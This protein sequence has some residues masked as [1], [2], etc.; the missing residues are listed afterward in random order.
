MRR[1]HLPILEPCAEDWSAM[2]GD[3]RRRHCSSC[4][5]E[6]LHLSAMTAEEARETLA[7]HA[8]EQVC[9]RYSCDAQDNVVFAPRRPAP[10]RAAALATALAACTGSEGPIA[11]EPPVVVV[12]LDEACDEEP[13]VEGPELCEGEVAEVIEGDLV[14]GT[15]EGG[16]IGYVEGVT[17]G[18]MVAPVIMAPALPLPVSEPARPGQAEKPWHPR[19]V[20]PLDTWMGAVSPDL[21]AGVV[22]RRRDEGDD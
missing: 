9:V 12:E 20:L 17:M 5:R 22:P 14:E 6:V 3:A 7:A 15:V 19:H 1:S 21:L 4:A 13:V 18:A 8:G 10:L 16:V 2:T 11:P